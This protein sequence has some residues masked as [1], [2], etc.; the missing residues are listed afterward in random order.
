MRMHKPPHPGE[1]IRG[2]CLEPLGLSVT[3]AAT[4]LGVT[5]KALSEL[6]NGHSGISPE[7]AI[8]LAKAFGGSPESW[9]AQ[10][11]QYELWRAMRRADK[12]KVE[13]F[14]AA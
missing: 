5:R 12:I 13:S 6:L 7:M 1:V 4:G 3:K 9:L 10:Q 2:L 11:M 8:R 14:K